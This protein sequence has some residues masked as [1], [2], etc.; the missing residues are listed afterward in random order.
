[1]K[2]TQL[3][4]LMDARS[5]QRTSF[6]SYVVRQLARIG[7][8]EKSEFGHLLMKAISYMM[9]VLMP[10]F[11]LIVFL[12]YRKDTQYYLGTLVFSI[13]YHSFIFLASSFL[14]LINSMTGW[15]SLLLFPLILFPVYLFAALRRVYSNS[16]LWT[17][18]K[19]FIIGVL[20]GVVMMALFLLTVAIS[21]LIF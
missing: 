9:F 7:A 1:M 12:F 6:N 5:I 11:A 20:Q 16:S 2:Q 8:T 14:I 10:F 15:W 13:H 19:M 21:V 17:A 18:M 4:S 3:D